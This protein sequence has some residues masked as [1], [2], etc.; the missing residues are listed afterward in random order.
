M[1]GGALPSLELALR[2]ALSLRVPVRAVPSGSLPRFE[3][4]AAA[5]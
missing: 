3:L 5:D 2:Q 4:K 1:P